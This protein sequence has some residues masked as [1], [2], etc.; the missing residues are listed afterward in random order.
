MVLLSGERLEQVQLHFEVS[1]MDAEYERLKR[2]G[3]QFKEPLKDMRWRWRH[4]YTA[5][6]AGRS[7]KPMSFP[8]IL[9]FWFMVA[10]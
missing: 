1:D 6:P 2:T 3:A 5:D 7:H 9:S 4:A 8:L 10:V